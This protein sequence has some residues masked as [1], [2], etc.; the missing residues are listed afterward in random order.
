MR[1]KLLIT[2]ALSALAA[3]V[4]L[5]VLHQRGFTHFLGIDTQASDNYDFTSGI[6]PMLLTAVSMTTLISGMFRHA[7]CHVDGCWRLARYP[8]AGGQFRVCRRHHPDETIR[9]RH[10]D[11]YHIARA[12]REHQR[13]QQ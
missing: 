1:S 13:R 2:L 8:V 4:A 12:H 6:G 11:H 3:A 7:N 10:V 5:C 9:T